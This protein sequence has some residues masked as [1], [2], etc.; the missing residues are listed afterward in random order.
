[1]RVEGKNYY[2]DREESLALAANDI[3][4]DREALRRRSNFFAEID[5][6][7]LD[8]HADSDG[9]IFAQVAELAESEVLAGL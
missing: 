6:T 1:M 8:V 2:F 4:P 3:Y 7:L 9:N 5:R